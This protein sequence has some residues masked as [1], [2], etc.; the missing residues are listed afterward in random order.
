MLDKRELNS[1]RKIEHFGHFVE[2]KRYC[3]VLRNWKGR[4][5]KLQSLDM[6]CL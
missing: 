1:L 6:L 2:S 5:G 4:A 3:D